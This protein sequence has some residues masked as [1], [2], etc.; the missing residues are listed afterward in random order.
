MKVLFWIIVPLLFLVVIVFAVRN[1]DVAQ[2]SLW[3]A[4][5]E[6]VSA[7]IYAIA[8]IGIFI[9]FL[10]GGMVAWL[11]GS[12]GRETR[13]ALARRLQVERQESAALREKLARLEAAER[14]ATIP[15]PPVGTA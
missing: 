9:G 2:V 3:P 14:Q 15:S 11:Q 4:T 12:K 13:R 1:H 6:P 8:L 7:P 10:W 5:T